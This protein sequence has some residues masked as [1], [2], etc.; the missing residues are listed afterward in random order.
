MEGRLKKSQAE[1]HKDL[2]G[3]KS[4]WGR[5][6]W[7]GFPAS[8]FPV[9]CSLE[10]HA[11]STG[12]PIKGHTAASCLSQARGSPREGQVPKKQFVTR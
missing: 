2:G 12:A 10:D 1:V 6:A 5:L 4:Q 7:P 8:F 9:A 3:Q 11:A